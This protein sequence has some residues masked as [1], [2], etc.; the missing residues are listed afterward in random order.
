MTTYRLDPGISQNGVSRFFEPYQY[1]VI[2]T[3]SSQSGNFGPT[4]SGPVTQLRA[5]KLKMPYRHCFACFCSRACPGKCLN[6]SVATSRAES[7]TLLMWLS[8]R[9]G[10]PFWNPSKWNQGLKPAVPLG[11]SFDPYRVSPRSRRSP[12]TEVQAQARVSGFLHSDWSKGD[13]RPQ[14]KTS[15]F[16]FPRSLVFDHDF[17]LEKQAC[18]LFV[19][20]FAVKSHGA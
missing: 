4:Q 5:P 8:V 11:F 19:L 17:C 13:T 14:N 9:N 7:G 2:E 20:R 6:H 18:S 16:F 3:D 1:L 15:C 10:Y 12:R